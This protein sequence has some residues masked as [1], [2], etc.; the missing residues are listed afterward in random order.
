MEA[1]SRGVGGLER[2]GRWAEETTRSSDPR[3]LTCP[4]RLGSGRGDA[5]PTPSLTCFLASPPLPSALSF[6]RSQSQG[7][8]TSPGPIPLDHWGGR[9]RGAGPL[10]LLTFSTRPGRSS[11]SRPWN[12]PDSS[13]RPSPEKRT[14][15]YPFCPLRTSVAPEDKV[16]TG[17][18]VRAVKKDETNL[19]G[20]I[21][22]R[23]TSSWTQTPNA[24]RFRKVE[25]WK[26]SLLESQ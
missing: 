24:K 8:R 6:S 11:L 19:K 26:L 10:S 20:C 1:G 16:E 25:P 22:P 18:E 3:D 14:E 13:R 2:G 21:G 9:R 7:P 4:E 17:Q 23:G 12:E 5:A 15:S